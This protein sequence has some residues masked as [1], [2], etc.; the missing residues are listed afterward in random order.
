MDLKALTFSVQ[1]IIML[2]SLVSDLQFCAGVEA[3]RSDSLVV[4]NLQQGLLPFSCVCI[5]SLFID[6]ISM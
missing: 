4:D 1:A 2:F 6:E 3:D 5:L